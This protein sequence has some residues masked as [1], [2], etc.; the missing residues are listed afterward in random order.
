MKTWTTEKGEVIAYKDLSDS[1]LLNILKFIKRRSKEGVNK[2]YDF[3]YCGDDDFMS[4]EVETIYGKEVLKQLD[5]IGLRKEAIKR[6][7]VC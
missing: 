3:G 1:H 4:G 7:L 5:Y 6:K 2:Y